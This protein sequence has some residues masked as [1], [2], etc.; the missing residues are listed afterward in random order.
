M[1]RKDLSFGRLAVV[2]VLASGIMTIVA[3]YLAWKGWG[4]W[5]LVAEHVSGLGTRFFLTWA[6]FRMWR[7]R[8]GWNRAVTRTLWKF[9]KPT[10]AYSNLN[11]LLDTFD[12]FWVGSALGG[13]SLG[14]Y[15]K[16][17]DFA[18]YPRR[19][20]A[21]PLVTVFTPIFARLQDDRERL[22]RAFYRSA[23]FIW[24][25]GLL[26]AG[27]FS[28]AMP[29]FIAFVIGEKW[30]PMLLAFRLLIIYVALDPIRMLVGNLL[31]VVAPPES[32]R[33]A[34]I[35][36]VA[37]F[38][39][40]VIVG[41]RFGGIEGVALAANGM[42]LIGIWRLYRPLR[43]VVDFSL[44]RLVVWPAVAFTVA[45]AAGLIVESNAPAEGLALLLFKLGTF[46]FL[47]GS[48]LVL[49]E[50]DDYVRG[51]KQIWPYVRNRMGTIGGAKS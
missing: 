39:P 13:F 35:V 23:H 41:A 9:G 37:F 12:D 38:F 40:A 47:F 29:E 22:S 43:K 50:R 8:F 5:A 48:L 49:A 45:G 25:T 1:L 51:A 16:A 32:L 33:N 44:K 31:F 24:R 26:I 7:P 2:D 15:S 46:T 21:N 30:L 27:L 14:F 42:L 19:V 36:Q 20:F 10:W 6:P 3:P 28:L 4:V 11:H 18:R 34:A 17:Y